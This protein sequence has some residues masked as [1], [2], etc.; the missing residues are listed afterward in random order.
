[1]FVLAV[2]TIPELRTWPEP[3]VELFAYSQVPEL[4]TVYE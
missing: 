4:V 3:E 2:S 1:M